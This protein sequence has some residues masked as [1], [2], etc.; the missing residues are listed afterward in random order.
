MITTDKSDNTFLAG[1]LREVIKF[2]WSYFFCLKMTGTQKKFALVRWLD[3]EQI[4]VMS[5]FAAP[6]IETVFIGAITQMK[7]NEGKK[8][9]DVEI[10]KVSHNDVLCGWLCYS[11]G[12]RPNSYDWM[13]NRKGSGETVATFVANI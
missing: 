1:V 7:W 9:Y 2:Y 11:L 12:T 5:V 6:N 8:L 10:V 13:M 4:E 3:E